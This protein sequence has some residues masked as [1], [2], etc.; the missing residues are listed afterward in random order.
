VSRYEEAVAGTE[1]ALAKND[2][3]AAFGALR[4]AL[5]FPGQID[6]PDRWSRALGLFARIAGALAGPELE[7]HA[8]AVAAAPGD[9]QAL[10]DC[11][12]E[13][14]EAGL[15]GIAATVLTRAE[16]LA[17][18]DD[19]IVFELVPALEG[20]GRHAEAC[21]V[22]R[23]H[24]ALVEQDFMAAYLLAFNATMSADLDEARRL[25]PLLRKLVSPDQRWGLERIDGYLA[26][27]EA[28][29]GSAPL[30]RADLRG[31]HF[32]LTGGLLLHLSP[33]GAD[34][35]RGRY[36][37]VQDS[38]DLCLEGIR[39]V[40]AALGA[41]AL[42]PPQV[43][44][45]D[46]RASAIL[47]HAAAQVLGLPIASWPSDEPGLIAAYDLSAVTDL[48]SLRAHRPG[49]ILWGH[50]SCW[51]E[52]QPV[53]ADL[54]TFLH[55]HNRPLGGPRLKVDPE[56]RRTYEAD[57]EPGT[58]AE[59]GARLASHALDPDA[60]ADLPALVALATAAR[61]LAAALRS[62]GSREPQFAGSP[63]ASNRFL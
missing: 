4:A 38:E 12:Y 33:H 43:F 54:V 42:R 24:A 27:A 23:R 44:V 10:F 19:N 37:F 9:L 8:R 52:T 18:D 15:P 5:E 35:M 11:G 53:A 41:L 50:T 60:L 14:I 57:P 22:L 55:Q 39:R 36:A 28:V 45:L 56:T 20:C 34:V 3:R 26:R 7:Q 63:V 48:E 31:W 16:R 40:Q 1:E 29:R 49:Q 58:P 2:A 51:T 61:P 62:N 46:D 47:G 59:L 21:Q 32:V 25:L 17:P 13:L 6:E 30:D